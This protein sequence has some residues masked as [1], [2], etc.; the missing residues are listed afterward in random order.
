MYSVGRKYSDYAKE[1][2]TFFREDVHLQTCP[3]IFRER[4][5]GEAWRNYY[6][7]Q[8]K[9]MYENTQFY[10]IELEGGVVWILSLDDWLQ[11]AFPLETTKFKLF[12]K[13]DPTEMQY[14]ET[15]NE[16]ISSTNLTNLIEDTAFDNLIRNSQNILE[17]GYLSY[18]CKA[19]PTNIKI[20]LKY[21]EQILIDAKG[22]LVQANPL[23]KFE[24][25]DIYAYYTLIYRIVSMIKII[26]LEI[27]KIYDAKKALSLYKDELVSFAWHPDRFF[28]WVLCDEEKTA[29]KERW[30]VYG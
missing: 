4:L 28:D 18:K 21:L 9:Y 20:D 10:R 25:K 22:R 29:I 30:C 2:R 11:S 23:S 14:K 13:A 15:M 5:I 26:Q 27:R 6:K 8:H 12:F 1:Q 3:Y 7:F 17:V 16:I 19:F 24:N